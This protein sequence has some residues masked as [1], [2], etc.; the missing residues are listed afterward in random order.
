MSVSKLV[1]PL[2]VFAF[3]LLAFETVLMHSLRCVSSSLC[4]IL[5]H[6]PCSVS[7]LKQ[8]PIVFFVC[9]STNP[10]I[11]QGHQVDLLDTLHLTSCSPV[12]P[13]CLRHHLLHEE[14]CMPFI[15]WHP[16][17]TLLLLLPQRLSSSSGSFLPFLPSGSGSSKKPPLNPEDWIF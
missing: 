14:C 11:I 15:L 12:S 6:H 8:K 17:P 7:M 2:C 13:S 9:F 16:S 3:R 4:L 10:L 1:K 5:E